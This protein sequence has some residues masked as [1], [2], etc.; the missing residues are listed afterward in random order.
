MATKRKE[1]RDEYAMVFGKR[2]EAALEAV[3]LS[4]AEAGRRMEV[5]PS[6]ISEYIRGVIFP[7]VSTIDLLIKTLKL[8]PAILFPEWAEIIEENRMIQLTTRYRGTA[9]KSEKAG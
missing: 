5:P 1:Q 4:Q 2:L 9:K 7:P 3:G 6:R 8:D